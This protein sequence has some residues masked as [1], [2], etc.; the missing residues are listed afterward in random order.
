MSGL[1]SLV[2]SG[3]E[4]ACIDQQ[5]KRKLQNIVKL[6]VNSP[7]S[8]VHFVA[9]SL[10]GTALLH[11]KQVT[12]F[13]MICRLPGDPLHVY[14]Q[15]IL[16]SSSSP[17]SWFLQVRDLFLMYQ[18][19]HPLSLLQYP[20][21]KLSFKKLAKAKVLDYWED[22]LRKEAALLPSLTNCKPQFM[23][24][25]SPHKIWTT[26]GNKSHEVAKARIQ[27]LLLSS[28]YPCAML[29]SHWG[30]ENDQGLCTH[31]PCKEQMLQE[32]VEH[33]LLDCPAYTP[34]RQNLIT[35]CLGKKDPVI[36]SLVCKYLFS[37]NFIQFLLD[38]SVLPLVVHYAQVHGEGIYRDL[39]YLSRTWCFALHR[40]RMKRLNK[41]NFR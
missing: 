12:L 41:W 28:K 35:M 26:A 22:K 18:L 15:H 29:T 34:T 2:L 10:P 19:P 4:I 32:S 38:C 3:K 11:L 27:M 13:S 20:P 9:G 36:H 5:Y 30:S 17:T 1:A 40:E 8:L 39:F 24:L 23:S 25:T 16:T 14:A 31:P 7:S 33:I 6:P 21:E 37:S